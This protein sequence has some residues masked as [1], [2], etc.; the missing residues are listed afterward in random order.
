MAQ[1]SD[2]N[3]QHALHSLQSLLVAVLLLADVLH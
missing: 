2:Q 3:F 1:V